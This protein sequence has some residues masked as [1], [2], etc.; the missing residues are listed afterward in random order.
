M[1]ILII[2]SNIKY[3]VFENKTF[4]VMVQINAGVR[5]P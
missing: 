2:L 3:R 1:M 5:H 4:F